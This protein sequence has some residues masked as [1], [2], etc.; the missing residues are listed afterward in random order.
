MN[1]AIKFYDGIAD[2]AAKNG[3]AIDIWGCA[4]DQVGLHEMKN[5]VSGT[6]GYVIQADSFK[7]ALFVQSFKRI[8]EKDERG[9]ID[10][11]FNATV[12]IKTSREVKVC[13]M[14]GAG[15]SLKVNLYIFV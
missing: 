6:G 9:H 5:C 11:N 10:M 8:W 3:H 13:G 7:S 15:S 4:L 12:E 1:K 2:R 14:I